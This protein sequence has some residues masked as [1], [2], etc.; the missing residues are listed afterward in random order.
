[1]ATENNNHFAANKKFK[2]DSIRQKPC[3]H[4]LSRFDI[5]SAGDLLRALSKYQNMRDRSKR[6]EANPLAYL[7]EEDYATLLPT[8]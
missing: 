8:R 4:S 1:V 3:F 7:L 2:S 5:N 6:E